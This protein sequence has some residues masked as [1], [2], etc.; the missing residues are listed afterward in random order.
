MLRVPV[1]DL[2]G[3]VRIHVRHDQ[4]D[5]VVADPLGLLGLVGDQAVG[6]QRR[7][8]TAGHLGGVD[9]E[10]DPGDGLALAG[11]GAGLSIGESLRV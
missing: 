2:R 10:V 1:R 11:Q 7:G 4:R 8:L 9:A 3:A 5:D 6:E